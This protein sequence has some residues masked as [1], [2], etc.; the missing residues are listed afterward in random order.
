MSLDTVIKIGK[1]YREIPD[2]WKYHDQINLVMNDV[3]ALAK[4]KDKDGNKIETVFIEIPVIDKGDSFFFD[5]DNKKEIFDE[6]KRKSLYYLN[7]KTSKKDASKR[8]LIGD[9]AYSHFI[10]NK[11]K[12]NESGNYRLYGIWEGEGKHS[13]DLAETLSKTIK[14]KFIHKFRD[15]FR[16][17][18]DKIE[19]LLN[20]IPAIVLHF[21]FNG[22]RWF[23]MEGIIDEID[24]ILTIELVNEYKDS[25]KVVLDKYL[26]KTL[27][28]VTPG[29]GEAK[30]KNRLFERD[31]IISLMYASKASEKPILRIN[32][33]GIIALPHSNKLSAEEV[34]SFFER[35]KNNIET[36]SEKEDDILIANNSASDSLFADFTDNT[37]ADEVKFDIIFTSIPS[38]PAGVFADLIEIADVEKSLLKKIHGKII[39]ERIKIEEIANYEFPV[40]KSPFHFDVKISFLKILGDVTKDKKKFQFHLLKVLPQIYTDSYYEDPLILPVF[41]EKVEHNIRSGGLAFSTLK[42]DFYFLM[43]IQ[44]NNTMERITESKSY[45][46]GKGLGIMA[47]QFAAWRDDCPIKSFEKS[48]VGNLSRRIS[49][50]EELSKFAGFINEKLIIHE[51]AYK[52]EKEAY[53]NL[54]EIIKTF[55]NEKYSKHNCSLGFFE[56]YYK[57]EHKSTEKTI[58]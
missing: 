39:S 32:N 43:N 18:K 54:V 22:K 23:E 27:G 51:R 33:I 50:I 13:F 47:K 14:N 4:K 3:E 8:Y 28:G 7:F 2:S 30:H 10:D 21:S 46:L 42:Y 29:F 26:Y 15:E 52:N 44:K 55:G 37:F 24:K 6:D 40:H 19:T 16:K 31:E 25:D 34:I 49:S 11:G 58:N 56:S 12:L 53:L 1:F 9:L 5:I 57:I 41:L 38:S 36:E 20:S 48:Y 35:K 45:A 17:N